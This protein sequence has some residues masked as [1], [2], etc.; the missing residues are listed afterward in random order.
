MTVR[1]KKRRRKGPPIKDTPGH[2]GIRR[3][4]DCTTAPQKARDILRTIVSLVDG[5]AKQ[6]RLGHCPEVTALCR[7]KLFPGGRRGEVL[8]FVH[9]R[10]KRLPEPDCPEVGDPTLHCAPFDCGGSWDS[11]SAMA[12]L[13]QSL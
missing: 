9:V 8:F 10:V 1:R 4:W 2:K 6:R 12:L 3:C 7:Q 5:I 13:S 11:H